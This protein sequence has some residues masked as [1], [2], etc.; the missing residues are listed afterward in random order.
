MV[1]RERFLRPPLVVYR[2]SPRK[3]VRFGWR[4]FH[5]LQ[6]RKIDLFNVDRGGVKID[7]LD[8]FFV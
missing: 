1:S 6:L 8:I 2:L 5:Y 4:H 3:P 7:M